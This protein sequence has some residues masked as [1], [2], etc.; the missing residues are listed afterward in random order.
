MKTNSGWKLLNKVDQGNWDGYSQ[1]SYFSRFMKEV[2]PFRVIIGLEAGSIPRELLSNKNDWT[3]AYVWSGRWVGRLDIAS[4]TY[5]GNIGWF[6]NVDL[7]PHCS[8]AN[9]KEQADKMLDNFTKCWNKG[10]PDKFFFLN[11]EDTYQI[12]SSDDTLLYD[13]KREVVPTVVPLP[14]RF[15]L[16]DLPLPVNASGFWVPKEQGEMIKEKEG[17][18]KPAYSAA[19]LDWAAHAGSKTNVSMQSFMDF[20]ITGEVVTDEEG[21]T[22]FE[23][24][25]SKVFQEIQ[26]ENPNDETL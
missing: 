15:S 8:L 6:C 26:K 17:F 18:E 20:E 12:V 14:K 23:A 2:F 13:G 22:A 16:E 25:W 4:K 1:F 7:G 10:N 21:Q 3:N 19:A 9:L 24:Q 5:V 11:G